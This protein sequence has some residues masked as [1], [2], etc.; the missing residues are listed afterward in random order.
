[1]NSYE[2]ELNRKLEELNARLKVLNKYGIHTKEELY[3]AAKEKQIDIGIFTAPLK[4][5]VNF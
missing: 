2:K 4:D 1:M 5:N 3:K